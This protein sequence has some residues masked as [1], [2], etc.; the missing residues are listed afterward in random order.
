LQNTLV[1]IAFGSHLW[2]IAIAGPRLRWQHVAFQKRFRL[3]ELSLP[4]IGPEFARHTSNAGMLQ[5]G[6][7]HLADSKNSTGH[8][9]AAIVFFCDNQQA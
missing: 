9:R 4:E 3:L 6:R 7:P 5:S 1:S 2:W 8:R